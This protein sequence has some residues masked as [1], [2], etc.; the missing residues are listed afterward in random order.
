MGPSSRTKPSA[1][2]R[3]P[4]GGRLPSWS[5]NVAVTRTG[6]TVDDVARPDALDPGEPAVRSRRRSPPA[7]MI[8]RVSRPISQ[9]RPD[10]EVVDVEVR[11]QDRVEVAVERRVEAARDAA[12][13]AAGARRRAGR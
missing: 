2:A 12:Q 9:E 10:V 11:D 5:A 4:S 13:D 6:P 7:G 1:W 8:T 3:G